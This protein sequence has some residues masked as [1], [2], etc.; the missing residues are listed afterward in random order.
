H[1]RLL[2]SAQWADPTPD[3]Q[4]VQGDLYAIPP[5]VSLS[6]LQSR[7]A[8]NPDLLLLT[9]EIDVRS[10]ELREARSNRRGDVEWS[11]GVR[12][13]QDSGDS[14]AVVGV[15]VPLGSSRRASGALATATAQHAV[16]QQAH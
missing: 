3:F 11:A 13:L 14:A 9:S 12:R 6:D 4:T 10:A 2:L 16:A 15:S 8:N 1:E 7:L 5:S